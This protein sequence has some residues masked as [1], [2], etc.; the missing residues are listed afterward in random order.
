MPNI[1]EESFGTVEELI[2]LIE[3]ANSFEGIAKLLYGEI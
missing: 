1:W 3:K 2:I